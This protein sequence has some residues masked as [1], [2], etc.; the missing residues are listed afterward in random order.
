MAPAEKY[1]DLTNF[2]ALSFDC[3]GTLI[4]WETGFLNTVRYL[5]SQLPASHPLNKEPPTEA[6]KRLSAVTRTYEHNH[7]TLPYNEILA[8]A[9]TSFARDELKLPG[10]PDSIAE[11][12]GNSPGTW[13]PFPDTIGGLQKLAK[14]YKLVILSNVDNQNISATLEK[15]AP[16]RFDAVYTAQDIGSYKPARRNFEYLFGHLRADLGVDKDKGEL[17]HVARSLVADHVPAKELGLPSVWI[18]RGG[19]R[20]D[21][22]GIGGDYAALRDKVAF[23]WRFDTIGDF[24]DE[25]E[26]QFTAKSMVS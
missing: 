8:E 21:G 19:D 26:R 7:P 15:L 4:D 24:A 13:L 11:P 9:I 18:S 12:F 14:H 10:L 17:L 22:S 1:P 2:K 6:M 5:T 20:K 23:G 3:Y 16:A 25:V